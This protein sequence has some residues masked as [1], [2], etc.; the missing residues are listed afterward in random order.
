[1]ENK[2]IIISIVAL[3]FLSLGFLIYHSEHMP[4]PKWWSIYFVNTK[5]QS[6]NFTIENHTSKTNFHWQ[7][8]DEKNKLSEG[9]VEI[10]KDEIKDVIID[11]IGLNQKKIN[12]QVS[13]DTENREIYKNL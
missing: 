13:S 3:L 6:L 12:I 11:N 8:L 1:M 4:E 2:K 5:D 10:K 7:V 9:D